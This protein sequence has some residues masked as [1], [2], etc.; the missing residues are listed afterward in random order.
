MPLRL[1][2]VNPPFQRRVRRIA[3]T[4]VGPPLGLAYLAAAARAAGHAVRIVDANALG[5]TVPEAAADAI[6]DAPDLVGITA[7]TPTI[8]LAGAI[9]AAVKARAPS[10]T[11]VVGGPHT[12]F[13]PQR[14]L[15]EYPAVDIA[16]RGEAELSL[17]RL[18]DA[19]AA[20]GGD[21]VGGVAGFV[22]RR[23]DGS[24]LDTGMPARAALD[25]IAPPARDLL[26]MR[27]YRTVDSDTFATLLAMRGCP[28]GCV[29]CAVPANFGRAMRYRPVEAVVDEM[30]DVWRR[31]GVTFFSFLDDTFTTRR[32]WVE[33][34]CAALHRRGLPGRIRWI[35]LTRADMVTEEL[36][37]RMR[38]AGCVRVE[39]GIE[40]G[41]QRGRDFFHKGLDEGALERGF[42]AARAAGL[43]TMGFAILNVPGET[44]ADI[45][46][47]Y[48]LCR[49]LDPDFLQVSFLTPYP[50]TPLWDEA[51][52]QGWITTWD[53]SRY[54]FLNGVVLHNPAMTAEEMRAQHLRFVRRFYLRP[55]TA[56][57]LGRLVAN[58]TTR[59][60]PLARTVALG[61]A[62]T[63]LGFGSEEVR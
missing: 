2:L 62:S 37:V 61:L 49:R 38:R 43:S 55:R 25:E 60:G 29:Y 47:T 28:A 44:A 32:R 31:F 17:P 8:P 35:C 15:E 59:L 1:T 56:L 22:S 45:E 57:K 12:T 52:R 9:A 19:M 27:R 50:G 40:S 46:R 4:T 13:L 26:P 36:L 54:S 14:T 63:V 20:D 51:E 11:T 58:G 33:A 24:F 6:R 23:A 10:V 48:E 16:A 39:M 30:E 21:G 53:W 18:C 41:S 5:L 34:F 42:A 3:Q 7:T